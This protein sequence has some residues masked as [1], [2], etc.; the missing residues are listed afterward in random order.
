MPK[1]K[2]SD[3]YETDIWQ[4][5]P[6]LLDILLIDHSASIHEGRRRNIIWASDDYADLG[7]AYGFNE[8]ILPELI[9]GE[10]CDIIRP[11]ALKSDDIRRNRLK[12]HGEVSTPAWVC[13][14]QCNL[15]DWVKLKKDGLF[16]TE[17]PDR[18]WRVTRAKIKFPK[19]MTWLDYVNDTCLEIACGEAPYLVSRYDAATGEFIPVR[20]RIGLLDRKLRVAKENTANAQEWTEAAVLAYKSTYGYEWQGDSLLIARQSLLYSFIEYHLYYFKCEPPEE[21]ILEIADIISWNLWQMD[22]LRGVVPNSCRKHC[23]GCVSKDLSTSI[24]RHNG[25][26][27]VFKDW[28]DGKIVEYRILSA[29]T[30]EH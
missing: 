17:N 16:N 23:K 22:G 11:H 2:I 15:T 20:H 13:N 9:T 14:A 19:G 30:D 5:Y 18:T 26:Y 3:I 27:A 28:T 12:L 4:R 10:R 8:P 21:R 25:I 24:H 6:V 1:R 7:K 29:E